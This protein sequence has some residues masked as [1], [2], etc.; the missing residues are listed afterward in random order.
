MADTSHYKFI[1]PLC[2]VNNTVSLIKNDESDK[3]QFYNCLS[4]EDGLQN[5]WTCYGPYLKQEEA[6]ELKGISEIKLHN[7]SIIIGVSGYLPPKVDIMKTLILNS[8]PEVE[9]N[10]V[11]V[12]K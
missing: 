4:K 10:S 7:K 1:N 12:S 8:F 3:F 5:K 6:I 11:E 2:S 9:I